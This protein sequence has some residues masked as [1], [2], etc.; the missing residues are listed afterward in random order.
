MDQHQQQSTSPS[1]QQQPP[2]NIE[3]SSSTEKDFSM[4]SPIAEDTDENESPLDKF[5]ESAT[6]PRS[7]LG[8]SGLE[9][10]APP[11]IFAHGQ[12]GGGGGGRRVFEQVIDIFLDQDWIVGGLVDSI[13]SGQSA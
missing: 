5:N 7:S 6:L 3:R 13:S 9:P 2:L 12:S 11:Q 1:R 8:S 10:S 4:P